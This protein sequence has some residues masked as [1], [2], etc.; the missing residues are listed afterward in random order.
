[1]RPSP[2]AAPPTATEEPERPRGAANRS[3]RGR[4]G[5]APHGPDSHGAAEPDGRLVPRPGEARLAHAHRGGDDLRGTAAVARGPARPHRVAA[6][7]RAA[8]PAEAR[9]IRGSRW[10][11]RCGSTTRASTSTTTCA[12]PRCRARAAWSSCACSTGRDLLPAARPLEAAVGAVAR[13]GPRG[14]PLRA[15]QQDAPLPGGRRLRAWTSRRCCSTRR[16]RRR[17]S[18]AEPWTA[19]RRALRRDSSS[20]PA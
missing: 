12:T 9:S 11:G 10:A 3:R 1:M 17:R 15:D 18:G 2:T 4:I 14:Q 5:S 16:R 6:A 7:P 13:A 8:L 20:R 19:G